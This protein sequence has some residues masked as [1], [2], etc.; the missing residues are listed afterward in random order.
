VFLLLV[1]ART[2]THVGAASI[3]VAVEA[4]VVG[5]ELTVVGFEVV[6]GRFV[7]DPPQFAERG[8]ELGL[9]V[10]AGRVRRS[11][12]A[13]A[14]DQSS[15]LGDDGEEP[16]GRWLEGGGGRR[17]QRGGDDGSMVH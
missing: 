12:G 3:P 13:E 17:S 14:A 2:S 6:V 16:E 7:D 10:V 8:M 4:E 9:R 15:D 1:R 11:D 5:H